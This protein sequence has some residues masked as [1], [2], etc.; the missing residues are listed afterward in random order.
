M[1]TSLG[2]LLMFL[3]LYLDWVSRGETLKQH[4]STLRVQEGKSSVINCTYSDSSSSYFPWYKQVPG[5][6]PELIIDIHSNKDTKKDQRLTVL[7]N[8]AAKHLSL[9]IEDTQPGDAAV[10]FCAESRTGGNY[11]LTFG[12]ETS[13]IVHPRE[14]CRNGHFYQ[15]NLVDR[16]RYGRIL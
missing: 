14:C 12:R 7:L 10:Y 16:N 11:K 5:K 2:A 6:G 3:W 8:K 15:G 9:H 4:P 1:K 13:L